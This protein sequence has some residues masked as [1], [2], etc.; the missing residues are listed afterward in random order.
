MTWIKTRP[1]TPEDEEIRAALERSRRGY[2]AEYGPERQ[3]Q[4][5]FPDAVR[6]DSIVLSH[7]LIPAALEHFFAGYSALLDPD[8]PC[9]AGSTR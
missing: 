3:A 4:L 8:L 5:Q 2:P 6:E 9:R 7:S 1:P